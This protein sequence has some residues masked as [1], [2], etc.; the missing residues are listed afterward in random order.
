MN[1][2]P[3]ACD[4]AVVG[5]ISNDL[6]HKVRRHRETDPY[7]TTTWRQDRCIYTNHFASI[8]EQWPT[9]VTTVDRCIG[10]NEVIIRPGIDIAGLGRDDAGCHGTAQTKGVAHRDYFV[11]DAHRVRRT[12]LYS[13]QFYVGFDLEQGNVGHAVA[14]HHG[15]IK[16]APIG[17]LYLYAVTFNDVVIGNDLSILGDNETR[18]QPLYWLWLSLALG[19]HLLKA[20]A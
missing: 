11:T 20:L 1:A 14:A 8:V 13:G 15:G 17:K 3:T 4:R 5:Q 2:E 10:L 9:R 18:P 16:A 6:L 19:H 12:K 7:R